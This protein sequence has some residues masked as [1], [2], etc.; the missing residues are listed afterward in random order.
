[1]MAGADFI[2]TST[3]K[4]S[5]NA[6]LPVGLAM[7]RADPRLFRG[8]RLSDRLQAGRRHLHRQ[9]LARLAGAD[10]GRARPALAGARAVPLRRVEPAHRHR[11]PA[12]A[13]PDRPLLG[14]P[15][16]RHGVGRGRRSCEP[17]DE[18]GRSRLSF[19]RKE[20]LMNILERYDAMDYGPAPEARNEADAWLAGRDFGKALFI[21]GEWRAAA[22]GKTFDDQRA[23]RPASCWPRSRDA[24]DADVDAAVAAARK[25]LPKWSA[26]LRLRARQGAL[27]HRPRHAAPPAPVRGAGI[28]RQRQADP[29]KP[30]HRRAA[31]DPPF[32]PPCRLGAGAGPRIP[33]PQA[34]RRRRPDHPVE[35]PAADAGLEDRAGA[36]RR[37]HGG[38]EAGRIHAADGHPVCRDL[39]ARR[40]AEGRRQHP[41]RRPGARVRRSSIMPASTRSP[42]PARP[43]SAR[44][45]AR[46]PPAP[47][48]S[49]R[50]SSA[51]SRPSSSSRMPI[52][53]APSKAWSTASG[54][55]R[56]RSAAPARGCWCRKASPKPSSPRSR[57]AW[58]AA[59]RQPARQEHRHRPAG[60]RH[61]ARPRAR[62]GRRGRQAGRGMLAA[63]LRAARR[64]AISTC[65]RSRPALR[66]PTS[67]RRRRCSAR[68]WPP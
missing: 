39:R 26:A 53:T 7:V 60:R 63:G 50:W 59:R 45:S 19:S 36:G 31:G 52:S 44:S 28:D 64:A 21:G 61:P 1:M 17:E 34:G 47:A 10:E 30:R 51:A 14:Q 65:R 16:P 9:S 41:A 13:P 35:F 55:T 46:R 5:V 18:G 58:P 8:D 33:R 29:R 43:R 12:R 67:W 27:R 54:S 49:C 66:R 24:G 6:T 20:H 56:A 57:R 15:P 37:L 62:P 32:H 4:E 40:R 11:A 3:G 48:R 23:R 25:A 68:C 42:S 38:A 22:G 2:K